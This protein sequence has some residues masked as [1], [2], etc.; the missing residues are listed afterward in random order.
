M[1]AQRQGGRAARDVSLCSKKRLL[2][3]EDITLQGS[4]RR[5]STSSRGGPQ[6]LRSPGICLRRAGEGR[7]GFGRRA[8]ALT[9]PLRWPVASPLSKCWSS[10]HPSPILTAH[11]FWQPIPTSL[12]LMVCLLALGGPPGTEALDGEWPRPPPL[13]LELLLRTNGLTILHHSGLCSSLFESASSLPLALLPGHRP[14]P[15]PP[16]HHTAA[17]TAPRSSLST[18]VNAQHSALNNI[19]QGVF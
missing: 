11:A 12:L 1:P 7:G 10:E 13:L 18:C 8:A 2:K 16:H 6:G 17:L 5:R 4:S 3:P 14:G 9:L 15:V 19:L